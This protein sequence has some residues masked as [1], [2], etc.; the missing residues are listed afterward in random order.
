MARI[1]DAELAWRK[2]E[3]SL[4]WLVES[5]G[6]KPIRQGKGQKKNRFIQQMLG[7]AHLSTT[8]IYALTVAIHKLKSIHQAT[9]PARL[10]EDVSE[11][12]RQARGQ[13]T[14]QDL[15]PTAEDVLDALE[16]EADEE[17]EE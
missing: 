5:Q 11:L 1:P 14:D 9:H 17:N 13:G 8:E 3:V 7:H 15:D 12:V 4:L 10:P 2:T 16:R 6:Y